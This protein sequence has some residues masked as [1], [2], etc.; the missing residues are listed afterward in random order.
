[1]SEVITALDQLTL[2][3]HSGPAAGL[4]VQIGRAERDGLRQRDVEVE[5][6]LDLG[7]GLVLSD[8]VQ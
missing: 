6:Q 7:V 3:A 8:D 2:D 1:M 4:D 5:R